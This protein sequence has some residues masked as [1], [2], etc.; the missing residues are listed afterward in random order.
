MTCSEMASLNVNTG[1]PFSA[2]NGWPSSS[3]A[4]VITVPAGLPWISRPAS[5]YRV[6]LTIFE[7][8]KI[9]V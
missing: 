9:A 2:V 8:L 5:P 3:N 6:T 4:T 1:P 7:L